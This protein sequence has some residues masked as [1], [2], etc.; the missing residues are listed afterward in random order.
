[1]LFDLRSYRANAGELLVQSVIFVLSLQI[2]TYPVI[3]CFFHQIPVFSTI[4]NLIALPFLGILLIF[5]LVSGLL[6]IKSGLAICHIILYYYVFISDTVSG[7]PFSVITT[8]GPKIPVI[9][10]YYII[11]YIFLYIYII[12]IH[13]YFRQGFFTSL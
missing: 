2:F 11:I 1:M 7:L 3:S 5:G 8:A 12:H 4:L 10:I 9:I 13:I 6:F